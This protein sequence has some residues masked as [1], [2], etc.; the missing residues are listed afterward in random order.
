MLF[1]LCRNSS[2]PR[3]SKVDQLV[4]SLMLLWLDYCCFGYF[5]VP[6]YSF[7]LPVDYLGS[8]QCLW[9]VLEVEG[10]EKIVASELL[11]APLG[12]SKF[13][14]GPN[15]AGALQTGTPLSTWWEAAFEPAAR[16]SGVCGREG[17]YCASEVW[18]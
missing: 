12:F 10:A 1:T 15:P 14:V 7:P 11:P 4:Q 8:M 17:Q 5:V 13:L 3:K 16:D 9:G 2:F 6:E 18:Q